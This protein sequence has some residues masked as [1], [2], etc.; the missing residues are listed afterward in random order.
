MTLHQIHIFH[1]SIEQL[2][3]GKSVNLPMLNDLLVD[4]LAEEKDDIFGAN[5]VGVIL[6][7]PAGSSAKVNRRC[8]LYLSL[9]AAL[10]NRR[11]DI[12]RRG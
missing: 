7:T 5:L 8:S 6:K 12:C 10:Y 4:S 9:F 11:F 2:S 1:K 3:S